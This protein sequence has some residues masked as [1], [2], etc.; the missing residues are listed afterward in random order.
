MRDVTQDAITEK[1]CEVWRNLL[2]KYEKG[3][4]SGEAFKVA[5]RAAYDSVSGFA[6]WKIVSPLMEEFEADEANGEFEN[7][8]E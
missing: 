7:G 3:T 5:F 8:N 4:I 2:A 1:V 6:D